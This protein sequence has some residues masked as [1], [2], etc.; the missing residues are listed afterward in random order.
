MTWTWR[1][2]KLT[3]IKDHV[4]ET[5]ILCPYQHDLER[6]KIE[7]TVHEDEAQFHQQGGGQKTLVTVSM[8]IHEA[9]E[10]AGN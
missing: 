8:K 5:E 1:E 10:L 4:L 6:I 7:S 2:K 9:G 3:R